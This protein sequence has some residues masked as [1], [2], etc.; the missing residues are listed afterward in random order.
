MEELLK[1]KRAR[2]YMQ[3]L[4]EG[5]DPLPGWK[6]SRTTWQTRCGSAGAFA[7]VAS[8]LDKVIQN[9]G[10]VGG[11]PRIVARLG[12]TEE[13]KQA[14]EL[15]GRPIGITELAK[16]ILAAAGVDRMRGVSGVHMAAWLLE[17]GFLEEEF[18]DEGESQRVPSETGD[19]SGYHENHAGTTT[20]GVK[21]M[22]L[23]SQ[24]AQQFILT[25]GPEILCWKKSGKNREPGTVRVLGF[26]LRRGC[27]L[28]AERISRRLPDDHRRLE[29][30]R[31]TLSYG[32]WDRS[33]AKIHGVIAQIL[34][35]HVWP[36][37]FHPAKIALTS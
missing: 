17:K 16:R 35:R 4:S 36:G 24:E 14:V 34:R 31:M 30:P 12:L 11:G 9:G 3:A 37:N 19:R 13:Q 27:Y 6:P 26:L 5:V 22:N 2:E 33:T 23:Y 1:L 20:Y 8:V 25:T 10:A 18:D 7:Y 15:S 32:I 21:P 29:I 28:R